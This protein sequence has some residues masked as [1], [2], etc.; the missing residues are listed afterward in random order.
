MSASW[1]LSPFGE[2]AGSC[3]GYRH[4]LPPREIC[5]DKDTT[6]ARGGGQ[7]PR[8]ALCFLV[9]GWRSAHR[10]TGWQVLHAASRQDAARRPASI[11]RATWSAAGGLSGYPAWSSARRVVPA[12]RNNVSVFYRLRKQEWNAKR[13]PRRQPAGDGQTIGAA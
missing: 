13:C 6:R 1:V 7:A 5:V 12:Q 9:M 11:V 10:G 2:R 3:G 8:D 4:G